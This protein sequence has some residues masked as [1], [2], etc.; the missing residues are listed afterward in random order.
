MLKKTIIVMLF[1]L[2]FGLNAGDN[3]IEDNFNLKNMAL[4]DSYRYLVSKKNI[5][6][7][8][9]QNSISHK[10]DQK[11]NQKYLSKDYS[12]LCRDIYFGT[13]DII[14]NE[15]EGVVCLKYGLLQGYY[16]SAKY[17]SEI[18]Y[19]ENEITESIY[20]AG[21]AAAFGEDIYDTKVYKEHIN[22]YSEINNVFKAA[23]KQSTRLNLGNFQNSVE[24]YLDIQD[25]YFD[26]DITKNNNKTEVYELLSKGN[27]DLLAQE[28]SY[29]T[30]D[31]K[32][33]ILLSHTK[34]KDWKSLIEYCELYFDYTLNQ[35]CL[36]SLNKY[37]DS[38]LPALKYSLNEFNEYK[39]NMIK[40]TK[41]KNA[42][43]NLGYAFENKNKYAESIFN[44]IID[45]LNEKDFISAYANFNQGRK[46]FNTI[47]ISKK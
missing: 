43:Q 39:N 34:N 24:T 6:K 3:F 41:F 7:F 22:K 5:L 42:F 36:K 45:E 40:E 46:I 32:K 31:A 15:R 23:I 20:W 28:L 9:Q 19:L 18:S 29:L 30:S 8:I 37:T 38:T 35:Y 25:M 11:S 2:F 44:L 13:K 14:K 16:K 26:N 12:N 33:I 1:S 4:S 47:R 17:L 10:K 21:F 27:F